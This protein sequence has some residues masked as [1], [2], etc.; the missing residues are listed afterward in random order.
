MSR[1]NVRGQ[2]QVNV[3]VIGE[4]LPESEAI[5]TAE[6]LAFVADLHVKFDSR[7]RDLLAARTKRQ[8]R[9]DAGEVPGFLAETKDVRSSA[10]QVADTPDDLQRAL[11][12]NHRPGR[13]QNGDQ[14][15]Q[16]RRRCL[17]GRL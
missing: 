6:A 2:D 10:W 14:C 7:R 9:I 5:L 11:G 12:G 8:A 15:A 16:F 1:E 13:A 3:I 4:T 17:H